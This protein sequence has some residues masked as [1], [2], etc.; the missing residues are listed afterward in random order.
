MRTARAIA[1]E[2]LDHWRMDPETSEVA[3]LVVSELVTNSVEHAQ[4]PL[5]LHLVRDR[6]R[7]QVRVEVT[8]GGPSAHEGEWTASCAP[9]EHGRGMAIIEAITAAQGTHTHAHG[10]IHWASLSSAS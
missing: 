9:D 4:P 8:D 2:V 5:A 7:R 3:L 10:V 1:A 6:L